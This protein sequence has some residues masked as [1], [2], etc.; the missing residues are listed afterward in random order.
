MA[1]RRSFKYFRE[2]EADRENYKKPT[3]KCIMD[4]EDL[5]KK[6]WTKKTISGIPPSYYLPVNASLI[7]GELYQE[8]WEYWGE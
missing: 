4:N 3:H 2:T 6:S 1:K 7:T 5:I 8:M